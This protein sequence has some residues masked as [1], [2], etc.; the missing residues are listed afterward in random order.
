MSLICNYVSGVCGSGK[1]Q[2]AIKKI[3]A[4]IRNGETVIYVTETKQLLEQTKEGL[5][6]LDVHCNLILGR[7]QSNW[8]KKK[9]SVVK[10][11]IDIICADNQHPHVILCTSQSLIRAAHEIPDTIKLP[12]YID[13][14][15]DVVDGNE[16]ISTTASESQGL[17]VKL[18]LAKDKPEGFNEDTYKFPDSLKTLLKYVDNPLMIVDAQ[19]SGSKLQWNAYLDLPSFCEKFSEVT[20]LAACHEDTLQYYALK[21]AGIKQVA[22]NWGLA[23]EHVTNGSVNVSYVLENTE[24]RTTRVSKLFD[25]QLEDIALTF[26]REH[27]DKFIN[28]KQIG[29][30]GEGIKVKSH[31]FNNYS[32]IHHF[33]DLHTQMPIP[34][35]SKFY[36]EHL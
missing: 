29:D 15:F 32:H 33:M 31:G 16:I 19:A 22:L 12:L 25:T 1:T 4:R 36:Q 35:V 10:E 27:W 14:G 8:R 24:W 17:M 30:E 20:L 3:S 28:V 11:I 23:T 5:E 21:S 6:K 18:K 2:T 13:E 26:E 34:S 9:A 7:K